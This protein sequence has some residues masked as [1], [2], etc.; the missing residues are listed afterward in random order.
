MR[1]P[2]HATHSHDLRR[3]SRSPR[4]LRPVFEQG[5]VPNVVRIQKYDKQTLSIVKLINAN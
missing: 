4:E 3:T 1:K 2:G 5:P